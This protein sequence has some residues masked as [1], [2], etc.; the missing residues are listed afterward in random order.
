MV[1]SA[2]INVKVVP[3]ASRT[4]VV[5]RYG[6]AVKVQVAS[7]PEAGRANRALIEILAQVL[8]VRPAQIEIISGHS[9]PRKRLRIDGMDQAAVEAA[10]DACQ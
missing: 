8:H 3:G 6:D 9:A 10:L 5:G 2:I 7:P 4:S 1:P